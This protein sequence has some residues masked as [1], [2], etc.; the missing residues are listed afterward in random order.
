[1]KRITAIIISL[2]ALSTS[3]CVTSKKTNNSDNKGI[4]KSI[5]YRHFNN[6]T[7]E[8]H[9]KGEVI[10]SEIYVSYTNKHTI[11]EE[12]EIG[13]HLATIHKYNDKGELTEYIAFDMEASEVYDDASRDTIYIA[14]YLFNHKYDHRGN[15]I[16][17]EIY[18]AKQNTLLEKLSYKYDLNNNLIEE[19]ISQLMPN[20]YSS[21]EGI[22][23]CLYEYDD[24]GNKI[25]MK[26]LRENNI[27]VREEI[28][29]YDKDRDIIKRTI[30]RCLKCEIPVYQ[31]IYDS[32][33]RIREVIHLNERYKKI[34]TNIYLHD[35]KGRL[36]HE[37]FAWL[38][39][40]SIYKLY[41]EEFDRVNAV[42][43]I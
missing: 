23:A 30:T 33:K 29:Q 10:P 8:N 19:Q 34:Y 7:V 15:M 43:N 25:S 14:H 11:I 4:H 41:S 32:N 39:G 20:E 21:E 9:K 28:Y 1:M 2:L 37:D 6:K 42:R 16:M 40:D 13:G 5:S 18:D 31:Y 38:E 22:R 27:V 12:Y 35:D 26:G 3:G 36:T 17:K 24:I